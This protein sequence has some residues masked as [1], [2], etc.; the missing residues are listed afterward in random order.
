MSWK[1][2]GAET[3]D[4]DEGMKLAWVYFSFLCASMV[5]VISFTVLVWFL[6]C[7]CLH[8]LHTAY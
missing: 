2:A 7:N 6:F 3:E 8:V 1:A 5:M 4:L